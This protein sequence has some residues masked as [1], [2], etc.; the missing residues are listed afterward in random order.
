MAIVHSKNGYYRLS[1]VLP[2]LHLDDSL[3]MYC[4]YI[5]LEHREYGP[6]YNVD[7]VIFRFGACYLV[8]CHLRTGYYQ[9]SYILDIAL[10]L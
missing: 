9:A 6:Y 4:I 3:C 7:D 1:H 5:R 10:P 2:A 8:K